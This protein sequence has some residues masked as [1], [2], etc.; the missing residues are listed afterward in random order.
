MK[1]RNFKEIIFLSIILLIAITTS[2]SEGLSQ[3]PKAQI[4]DP[5]SSPILS[6]EKVF[7]SLNKVIMSACFIESSKDLK[8]RIKGNMIYFEKF[9][10]NVNFDQKKTF[11]DAAKVVVDLMS[12]AQ[13]GDEE[14]TKHLLAKITPIIGEITPDAKGNF[15]AKVYD[16]D[17]QT[18]LNKIPRSK[19]RFK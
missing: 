8:K 3:K 5:A 1:T 13:V 6:A 2:S 4:E 17:L 15:G 16:M 10:T 19:K 11:L 12:A 14:K 9:F 18:L 7:P